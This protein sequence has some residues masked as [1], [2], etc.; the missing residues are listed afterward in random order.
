MATDN[1]TT[2][3]VAIVTGGSGGIGRVA[4]ERLAR[5]GYSIVI[6]YAGNATARK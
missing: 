1:N 5:D 3:R 4:V 2:K 6:N